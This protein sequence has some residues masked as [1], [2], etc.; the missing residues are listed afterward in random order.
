MARSSI[1]RKY[2]TPIVMEQIALNLIGCQSVKDIARLQNLTTDR[3]YR[4]IRTADFAA[5]MEQC[6]RRVLMGS[7]KIAQDSVGRAVQIMQDA[8]PNVAQMM[9]DLTSDPS[10]PKA[11]R[12]QTA[13][14]ILTKVGAQTVETA[15]KAEDIFDADTIKIIKETDEQLARSIEDAKPLIAIP[16]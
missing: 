4:I 2:L 11:V 3:I 9:V 16:R 5:V 6:K 13:Q 14:S 12:S 10:C 8:A 15:K 7:E 1:V